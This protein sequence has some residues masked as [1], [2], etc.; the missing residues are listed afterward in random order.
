MNVSRINKETFMTLLE[1][2]LFQ[3]LIRIKVIL[4]VT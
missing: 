2:L 3:V 4:V 1:E